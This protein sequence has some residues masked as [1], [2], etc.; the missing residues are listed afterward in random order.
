MGDADTIAA[1]ATAPGVGGVGVIRVSGEHVPEILIKVVGR[2]LTPRLASFVRFLDDAGEPIDEGLAM[3]FPAPRSYTGEDVLEIHAH[4]GPVVLG[5]LLARCLGFGARL[6][7]PGEFTKRAFL[8]GKIDLA[9]AEAVADLIAAR[10][11]QAARSAARSLGGE[12]SKQI[13]SFQMELTQLR[14]VVEGAIDFPDEGIDFLQDA[15]VRRRLSAILA[16]LEGALRVGEIGRAQHEGLCAVLVGPP[17][18]GKSS[19]INMLCM[20][21]VAIV[22][23]LPGTTR[24]LV[25]A[26]IQIDGVPIEIIDTA[27]LR[28]TADLLEGLGIERTRKAVADADVVVV[29]SDCSGGSVLDAAI[30]PALRG[31]ARWLRVHNKIDLVDLPPRVQE[32]GGTTDVWVSA[33]TGAGKDDLRRAL[34]VGFGGDS[35]YVFAARRR[36]LLALSRCRD[37][38]RS[39]LGLLDSVE[40]LAEELRGA[41][42][43]LG[44]ITGEVLADDLLGEIFSS[45]CI[46]K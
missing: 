20:D 40:L 7:Q 16:L 34:V 25:R 4:G 18:S 44:E 21:E 42:H 37:C 38:V 43:A 31:H 23:P 17:N 45:F 28:V 33:L 3:H 27:G 30:L 24:D 5:R 1:V 8:N 2:A 13:Q 46:G 39:A 11:D 35:E 32:D 14:V 26:A 6:A 19:I 41:Q 12:F 22:S 36:H 9:Q 15:A 10:T 29:V